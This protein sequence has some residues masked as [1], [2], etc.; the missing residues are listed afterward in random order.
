MELVALLTG[1]VANAV[2][3]EVAQ[4]ELARRTGR[5]VAESASAEVGYLL[6]AANSGRYP[7]LANAFRQP[8]SAAAPGDP[9]D[10]L[11]TKVLSGL[12]PPPPAQ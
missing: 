12:L 10:R 5:S 8:A 6:A 7:N 1:F 3:Y 11:L 9:F 2:Q 4:T